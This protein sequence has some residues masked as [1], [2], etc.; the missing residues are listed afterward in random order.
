MSYDGERSTGYLA[1]RINTILRSTARD[2]RSSYAGN[3]IIT[4]DGDLK[5]WVP[6]V[7]CKFI[8]LS[9]Y[10]IILY[11]VASSEGASCGGL[12]DELPDESPTVCSRDFPE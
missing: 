3:A 11:C 2:R 8:W 10:D 1:W 4:P 6:W 5:L 12:E 7:A 9:K